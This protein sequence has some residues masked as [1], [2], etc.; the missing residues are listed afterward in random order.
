MSAASL[1][2]RLALGL[3]ACM[4]AMGLLSALA[5]GIALH[6][7]LGEA[8]D[9]ALEETAQRILPLALADLRTRGPGAELPAAV[10]PHE[11]ELVYLLRDPAGRVLA[12]SHN[13]DPE[14]FPPLPR[15]GFSDSRSLRVFGLATPDGQVIVEVADRRGHR[16]AALAESLVVLVVPM[17]ALIPLAVAAMLWLVRRSL[18]PLHAFRDGIERRSGADL[19]PLEIGGVPAE[20]VPVARSVNDLLDRLRRTL[21]AERSLTAN[22]AHELRTPIAGALAQ[23]QRLCAE[24]P[25]GEARERARRV[26][27]S[28][29]GLAR[30]AEKLMQLARAEGGGVLAETATDLVP[31]LRILVDEM[32]REDGGAEVGLDLPPGARL[33]SRMDPDAF[34]ILLRNLVENALKHG[35]ADR[36]VEVTLRAGGELSVRNAGR[37]VPAEVLPGLARRFARGRTAARGSGLGLAIATAIAEAGGGSLELHSPARGRDDGFEVAVRLPVAQ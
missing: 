37:M 19:S 10:P 35:G 16:R 7:E 33:V 12:R 31:V 22:S 36:H 30:L 17:L 13:A 34:G 2:R 23:A 29:R 24:L 26:A 25:P 27:D 5:S 18:A 1:Q 4:V 32:R 28:L 21:D 8:F 9:S 11:E 14:H 15:P 3:G 6:H 20:L